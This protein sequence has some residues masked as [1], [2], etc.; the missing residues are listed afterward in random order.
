MKGSIIGSFRKFYN[1][2]LQIIDL[3]EE[4]DISIL[5]PK[6]SSVIDPSKEF[7]YFLTDKLDYSPIEIQLIALHRILRSDFVYV[8]NPRGYIGRT[9]SFEI[10]RVMEKRIKIFFY[11]YPEDLP[12]FIYKNSIL[13]PHELINYY[14]KYNNF[15]EL[16]ETLSSQFAEE[17]HKN[18]YRE[19]YYK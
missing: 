16:S 19:Q 10:G 6:K 8:Y 11:E 17:L 13:K 5:S 2:V 9:T 12:I 1:E 4:A 14:H 18:L 15:P 7:V 3:F